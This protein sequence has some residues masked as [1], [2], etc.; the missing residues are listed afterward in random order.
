MAKTNRDEFTEKTVL[1]IAKRAGWLCS[2]PTC[3]TP[4][5]GATAG[6]QG[7]INIGAAAHICAAAPGGPRYD[8]KMSP[9][10]RS[11][12]NNGIWMCRDHGKAIDSDVAQFTADRLR[13]W[14][15]Q[16][17]TESWRRVLRNEAMRGPVV[18]ATDTQL[19]ARLRAAAEA[20]L[21]VFGRTAK[22]PPTSVALTLKVDGFSEPVTTRALAGAVTSLDDLILVAPP[23][24]GKTTTLFQIAEGVLANAN[25]TPLVVPL[26]DWATEGTKVLD[27]I[28][29]R[30]AFHGISEDDFRKAAAQ[31][32]VV[33]LLDGWNELDT[34]A[35]KRA[36]V[37]VNTLKAELPELG[38]VV[39]TRRQV[40]DAPFGGTRVDLLPLNEEQQM[41]IAVAMRGDAG[42]K[43]VDQAWR[44]AGVRELVTIPLYLRALLSLPANAP[45]PTTKEEILR[46]FVAANE[47]EASRAEALHA[48]TQGFHKDYLVGLAVFATRTANTSIADRHAKQSIFETETLLSD[49]GQITMKRQPNELLDVLVS[50]HVLMRVGDTPGISFQHQ[51]FQEWYAS[52][53]VEC[54]IIDEVSDSKRRDALKAEVFNLPTWEEA[55]FFAVE[56]LARGDAHQRAACGKAVVAAFEVDPILAAEM[57]FRS[58]D[59]VWTQVAAPIQGLVSRWHAQGKVDRAFRFMLTSGR[60]EFLNAVWPL[61]THDNEQ[62]SLKALRNCRRFRPSILGKDAEKT[63]KALPQHTRTV[64][65]HEMAV[66]SGMDGLDLASAI[67][68]D[69]PDPEV[70]AS[71][72]DALAFRRADRHLGVVLQKASDKTFDLIARYDL[73]DQVDDEQ[74]KK[75]IAAARKR[76]AAEGMSAYDRL[77]VIVYAQDGE[78]RSAELTDIISTMELEQRQ[79]TR[80][81][82]VYEARSR[83][84]RAVADGLLA[85]VRVG[86]TLIYGADDILASAG[87]CLEDEALLQLALADP[88]RHDD[89]AEAAAS[90]LGPRAA[91]RL[92]DALLELAPRLRTD[93]FASETYGGLQA[94]IAHVPGASLV[95]AVLERSARAGNEQMAHLASLLSR[96]PDR[97]TDRGRPFD[98]DSLAAI[99]GLVEDW[100][101]RMLASG[102]AQRWKKADIAS[103]ASHAPSVSLLP[104]LKRLLDDNL[105]RYRSFR[106]EATALGWRQGEA[107]NEAQTSHMI[108][109][110][111]AFMA[112]KAP[113]TAAL[114][115]EYLEDEHFGALA[116]QV[117]ADQWRTANE[118]RKDKRFLGGV[119]FSGVREK[120]SARAANPGATCDEAEAIF[121]AIERLIADGATE[122]QKKLGVALGIIALR[123]PHGQRDATIRKLIVVAPRHAYG[124]ARSELLLSLVLSG[125]EIDIKN[126]ADGIAET[127]EAA[128]T[129]TW[130]LT[131]GDGYELKRWLRLLPF[132]NRPTDALEVVRRMPNAQ[133]QPDFLDEMVSGLAETPSE[134]G[135]EVLFKFAEEDPRFYQNRWW[136]SAALKLGTPSAAHRLIDLTANGMLDGKSFNGWHWWRELGVL[137]AKFPEVR[138]H[139]YGLLKEGAMSRPLA[140]L[141]Q[142]VSESPDTEGLLLLIN[143]E[144]K[145]KKPLL[146]WGTIENVV[147]EHVPVENWSGAYNVVSVP[148]VK[149]R[150]ELLAMTMDGGPT[151][152]AARC[153]IAID[154]IRDEHGTPLS[155]PRHPD[156]ASGKP[157]PIMTPD[158]NATAEG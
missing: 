110:Q 146:A 125:E 93:R 90:V 112:I 17:E 76:Q 61:I 16:A 155:E 25:N 8:E 144:N 29:R 49:N 39:S 51:Q 69:D 79:D 40:L 85:R 122:V 104:I 35:R 145:L 26:G 21:K 54:R 91:G 65:L 105:Q 78:D 9:E 44:T 68:K 134:G 88:I 133:R 138:R 87:F 60:P 28:L 37:Q 147:T 74:V 130:I 142:A 10:E 43:I 136:R 128:K 57:I 98:V 86:R 83:Y 2:F 149:L 141:A 153:L 123:L 126:V 89:R 77:R 11:S 135:E 27:S 53:W 129:Q 119:D 84:P 109:Y 45:F 96:Y 7:E 13:E 15:R 108:E 64:L 143:I 113:E 132:V 75:G 14:K 94:R 131:Q 118:P 150:Q 73:V 148:A 3:R 107:V 127:F 158:P 120:R 31:P 50:N 97:E 70:Q 99:Q 59:E 121:A 137:I 41:R 30:P 117:L 82:L 58:T 18:A 102:D 55:I 42:A 151:D 20:D 52:H 4:T 81:Q 152:A 56:R 124:C 22:W 156:L 100:G 103:L 46:H 47:K 95:A 106:E 23:G 34:E 66:H 92:V 115:K 111:R 24:M 38:L 63:I 80:V 33:L 5:V 72:A 67:A 12:A 48:V 114:M 71:V 62:I 19:K 157:W 1:Q 139:V 6:G 140:L 36:R 116:A 154:V 32:G 101:A